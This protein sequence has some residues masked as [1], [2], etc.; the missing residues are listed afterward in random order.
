MNQMS[1]M[2]D[3]KSNHQ[4]YPMEFVDGEKDCGGVLIG[5]MV[6]FGLFGSCRSSSGFEWMFMILK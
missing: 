6:F 1:G 3:E 2:Q 4:K 5:R